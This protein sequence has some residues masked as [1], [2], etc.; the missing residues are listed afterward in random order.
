MPLIIR[1]LYNETTCLLQP[2]SEVSKFIIFI[3]TLIVINLLKTLNLDSYTTCLGH[4]MIVQDTFL[5]YH[6]PL[7]NLGS[8]VRI[9]I[10]TGGDSFYIII[11]DI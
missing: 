6:V 4:M 9:H 1:S 10:C 7:E 5:I 8:Y 2:P 3:C 11:I